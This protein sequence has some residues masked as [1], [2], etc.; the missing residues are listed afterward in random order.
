MMYIKSYRLQKLGNPITY[1]LIFYME[2]FIE[3]SHTLCQ[4]AQKSPKKEALKTH[5]PHWP[6]HTPT[7]QR[8]YNCLHIFLCFSFPLKLDIFFFSCLFV[9][10]VR[11]CVF[12]V[13]IWVHRK[14]KC[15]TFLTF[16]YTNFSLCS[17]FD[18]TNHILQ[19][20]DEWTDNY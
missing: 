4:K 14:A 2:H 20:H 17:N 9:W 19:P 5:T 8:S 10:L 6:T 3:Y 13:Q 16:C 18:I 1:S 11:T 7:K 15:S 12:G